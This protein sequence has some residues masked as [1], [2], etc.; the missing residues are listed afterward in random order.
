MSSEVVKGTLNSDEPKEPTLVPLQVT[1]IS[2]LANLGGESQEDD[3]RARTLSEKLSRTIDLG[4]RIESWSEPNYECSKANRFPHLR[5]LSC[6]LRPTPI[7]LSQGT[8]RRKFGHKMFLTG[9]AS[10]LILDCLVERWQ[11]LPPELAI[12]NWYG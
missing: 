3:I 8:A 4:C 2:E 1:V 12:T 5:R 11:D 10:N 7:S 6:C 9:G